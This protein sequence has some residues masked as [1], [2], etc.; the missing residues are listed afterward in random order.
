MCGAKTRAG[1]GCTQPAMDGQ[2]RCRFHGGASP[3][4]RRAAR[5]RLAELVDPA[6]ATL[7]REMVKADKSVDRQR[8][9][10]SIL[11][12]AG[13]GREQKLV[14]AADTAREILLRRLRDLRQAAIEA[15]DGSEVI[16]DAEVIEEGNEDE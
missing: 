13:F 10:N 5:I 7:G 2:A 8:A 15:G 4:A 16:V 1:G 14:D 6:I 9:A 11:D 3:Q 12:R